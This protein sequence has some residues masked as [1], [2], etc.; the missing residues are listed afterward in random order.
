MTSQVQLRDALRGRG[1]RV[2]FAATGQTGILVEGWGIA[3]DAVIADF[4]RL[5]E[6]AAAP[7]R[8]APVIAVALNTFDLSDE[9]ARAA[10]AA[11]EA[12][13]GLPAT[14]VVRYDPA[15]VADAIVDFHRKRPS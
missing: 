4:I 11:A 13:T 1:E 7:L 12:E 3:V 6:A 2:A 14:D 5:S 8:P 9:E 15:P 10:I